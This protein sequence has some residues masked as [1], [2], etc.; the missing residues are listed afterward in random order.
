MR[1]RNISRETARAI[2]VLRNRI[3]SAELPPS[4]LD[5]QILI[6][7][8][9]IRE[10]GRKARET[11]SIHLI[12]EILSYFDLIAIQEVRANMSDLAR[13]RDLL[14]P[15]WKIVFSD[16]TRGRRGNQERF[17]YL[18]DKRAVYFTGLAAEAVVPPKGNKAV[19]TPQF[20]R[21]PYIA[22]FSAGNFDFVL[23]TVHILWGTK[24]KDRLAELKY[25]ANWVDGY[26]KQKYAIDRDIIVLGDFNIPVVGDE[27]YKAVTKNGRGL[28]VP[29]ALIDIKGSNLGRKKHYDQILHYPQFSESAFSD[30]GGVVDFYQ[31]DH[32]ALY[33]KLTKH[34][35]TFQLSDHIP[36]WV[37][38]NT[39]ADDEQLDQ[40]LNPP[41]PK[42]KKRRT[43]KHRR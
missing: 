16:V 42:K 24:D 11:K 15:H 22:S 4:K 5:E 6:A 40:F 20:W 30:E 26:R 28:K 10:F 19:P 8:W 36:L 38:I 18:Y 13:V 32:K 37:Q 29:D 31:E 35:F 43:R 25:L 12:A 1:H 33:P 34:Q 9:N 7:S 21:T 14:G 2:K 41:A 3:E 23:L 17:A 39:D 27:F